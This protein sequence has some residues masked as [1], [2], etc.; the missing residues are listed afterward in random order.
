MIALWLLVVLLVNAVTC[1]SPPAHGSRAPSPAPASPRL[2]IRITGSDTVVNLVQAWAE[3]Y[4]RIRSAVSAQVAGGGSGVGI[5]GLIDGTLDLAAAGRE[6]RAD[7]VA[8]ATSLALGIGLWVFLA[9][10][11][12]QAAHLRS[13]WQVTRSGCLASRRADSRIATAQTTRSIA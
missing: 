8:R 6:V 10:H 3:H 11:R 2:V 4:A 12:F 9:H 7:E 1:T 13:R 5:A